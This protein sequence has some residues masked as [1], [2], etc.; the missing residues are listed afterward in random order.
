MENFE[1]LKEQVEALDFALD[2][3]VNR[4]NSEQKEYYRTLQSMY[5]ELKEKI[6]EEDE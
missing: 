2:F 3:L 5:F 4:I 6:D 1:I